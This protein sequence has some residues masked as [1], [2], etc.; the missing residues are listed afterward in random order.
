ME[1]NNLARENIIALK[2]YSSARITTMEGI[3][4]DANENPFD[5]TGFG[6]NRYP[7]PMQNKLREKMADYLASSK[8][9]IIFGIGSDELLDMIYKVFC[10]P[11]EDNVIISEPTYG[12]YSVLANTHNIYVK[13][14]M[15]DNNFQP[16]VNAITDACD[17]FTKLIFVCSPNNPT[18]NVADIKIIEKLAE[19]TG[20]II[21]VDEA[22]IDFCKEK[23]AFS[24]LEKYKN[25][26]I[27]RTFSKAMGMAGIRLGYA[28]S[29]PEIIELLFKVKLPYNINKLT[30]N[31]ALKYLSGGEEGSSAGI[32]INER[33]RIVN[34]LSRLKEIEEV[35]NSDA[36]FVLIKVAD[37]LSV[38]QDMYKKGI[39]LRYRG[40]MTGIPDTL[41]IT[42]GTPE[43]NNSMLASLSEVLG[44]P[45]MNK[46]TEYLEQVVTRERIV[47]R[48]RITKE[49]QIMVSVNLDGSG[50]SNISTG[51]GFL[52]H[53]LEQ[54]ARHGNINLDINV[55]GDLW[56]DEHH[57][58]EDVGIVLGSAI[59][60]ALGDKKAIK[61]YG[62][63]LPM[64]DSRAEVAIDLGGRPFLKFDVEFGRDKV[65]DL[66]TELVEEFFRGL[67]NN[68]LANIHIACT[69]TN[70]HHK[71]EAIFKAFAKSLNDAVRID[72]RSKHSL[73]STKGV[74]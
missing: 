56:I 60:D 21:V 14:L 69:G 44:E 17:D 74:L 70:D 5:E 28:I 51:I 38:Y 36:N 64:D 34:E 71:I 53:M 15:L 48:S 45:K 26:I 54:I 16:D 68:M 72:E 41:R 13:E 9:Q 29:S 35:F 25:I 27:L 12:M 47:K 52:D 7:D 3:L 30:E 55:S 65:G 37:A 18:G 8:E 31:I 11:A 10:T 39:I 49:T 62:F 33:A 66:P 23:S 32:I 73:P 63:L 59:K 57:T 43:E 42:I 58:V 50:K 67:S 4:L 19:N 1:I 6:I 40:N 24:L 46:L 2:T 20:K 61:R 22:Y